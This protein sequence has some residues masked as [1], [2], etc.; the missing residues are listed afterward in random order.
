LLRALLEY[1][2]SPNKAK[3]WLQELFESLNVGKTPTDCFQMLMDLDVVKPETN[4]CVLR[5][6]GPLLF[7]PQ[8]LADV[9]RF[10]QNAGTQD[11]DAKLRVDLTT[12]AVLAIDAVTAKE[13]DDAVGLHTDEQGREWVHVHVADVARLL[14]PKSQLET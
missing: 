11:R 1:A 9:P 2:T 3:Q 6:E 13:I 7:S 10:L 5:F 14:E 8:I 4:P 12:Q